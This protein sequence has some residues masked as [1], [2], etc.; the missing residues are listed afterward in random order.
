MRAVSKTLKAAAD[1]EIRQ[2]TVNTVEAL[3]AAKR[4]ACLETLKMDGYFGDADL[5]GLPAS[6]RSWICSRPATSRPKG[7]PI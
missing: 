4:Y 6:L 1:T 3:Q 2:L 5:E 7:S